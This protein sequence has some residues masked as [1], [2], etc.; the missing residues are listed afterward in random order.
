MDRSCYLKNKYD[1]LILNFQIYTEKHKN[2]NEI[3]ER[4]GDSDDR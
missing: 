1:L 2:K 3:T 4:K